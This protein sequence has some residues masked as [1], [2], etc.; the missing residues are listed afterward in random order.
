MNISD[1]KFDEYLIEFNKRYAY[2][3]RVNAFICFLITICGISAILYSVFVFHNSLFNRLRYMTFWGTIHTSFISYIF[4]NICLYEARHQT[5]L[6]YRWAYFLRLSSA[7]T[8]LVIF[9][10]VLIGLSPLVPDNPDITSYPGIMMHLIIPFL[11]LLSFIFN[12]PPIGKLKIYE[13]LYGMTF[14]S[15]YALVMVIVFRFD[16]LSYELAPYSFLDFQNT[17]I[18]FRLLCFIVIYT[19]GYFVSKLLAYLNSKL[20]WVWLIGLN[21]RR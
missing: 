16:I 5:E 17:T 20:S 4:G 2:K 7:T 10:I 12:D 1:N 19:V 15:I 13:P 14:I 9:V 11:T 21:K 6:T 18:G 8:E 3:K